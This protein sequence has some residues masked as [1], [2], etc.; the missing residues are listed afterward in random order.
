VLTEAFHM[1]SPASPGSRNLRAF[2][3]RGGASVWFLDA[4]ALIRAFALMEQ[5]AEHPMDL[6]DASLVVAAESLA[7]TRL[8]TLDRDDFEAYRVRRGRRSVTMDIVE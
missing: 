5:H 1:L 3:A 2:I 8:F 6:A 7:T 4:A